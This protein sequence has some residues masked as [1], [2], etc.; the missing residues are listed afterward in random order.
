M[1]GFVHHGFQCLQSC[2]LMGS[3]AAMH[4]SSS[5]KGPGTF[6]MIVVSPPGISPFDC[7]ADVGPGIHLHGESRRT[8]VATEKS[9]ASPDEAL[10]ARGVW[11]FGNSPTGRRLTRID[12]LGQLPMAQHRRISVALRDPPAF[13]V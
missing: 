9:S 2:K 3:P 5:S 12:A 13:S 4:F 11:K 6:D 10:Q 8:T 1:R 7:G